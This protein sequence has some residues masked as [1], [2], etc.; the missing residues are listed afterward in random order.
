MLSNH[1]HYTPDP[2]TVDSADCGVCGTAMTARRNVLGP[3]GFVMAVSGSKA[4]H[5]VFICPHY[6]EDWH[7]QIV[8]LHTAAAQT[9][10]GLLA[11]LYLR[12]AEVVLENRAS[13][14]P[15]WPTVMTVKTPFEA[16][17]E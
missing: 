7:R 16:P 17:T 3:R 14:R 6:S 5:D 10:S 12:E 13:S 15:K 9:P 2:G 11:Q 8:E 1:G 4:W